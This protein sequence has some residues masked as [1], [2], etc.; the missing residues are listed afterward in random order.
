M[1]RMPCAFAHSD[2]MVPLHGVGKGTRWQGSIRLNAYLGE[3]A[4]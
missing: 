4:A 3:R 1:D 2:P